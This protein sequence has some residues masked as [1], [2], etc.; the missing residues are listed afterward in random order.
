METLKAKTAPAENQ[1]TY[2]QSERLQA[3]VG[4]LLAENQELRFTAAKLK[5][6][7][8]RLENGL[9]DSIPGAGMLI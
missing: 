6:R 8:E 7:I 3:L 5:A 2:E 1:P 4:E 9:S